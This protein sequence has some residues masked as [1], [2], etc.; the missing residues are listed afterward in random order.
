VTGG[1]LELGSAGIDASLSAADSSAVK[2]EF[3]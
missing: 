1:L 2:S 3:L